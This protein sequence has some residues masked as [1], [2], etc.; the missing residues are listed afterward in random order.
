MLRNVLLV[1][2]II[3]W[4]LFVPK[5]LARIGVSE[6]G[7]QLV[8]GLSIFAVLAYVSKRFSLDVEAGLA[9]GRENLSF[10]RLAALGIGLFGLLV[11]VLLSAAVVWMAAW[12][13]TLL[14]ASV[15]LDLVAS[16]GLL[17]WGLSGSTRR[18]G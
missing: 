16:A 12:D 3:A 10:L 9:S 13:E 15:L 5:V 7:A 6:L 11:F 2:G 17:A 14:L 4:G 8:G 1:V 18:E